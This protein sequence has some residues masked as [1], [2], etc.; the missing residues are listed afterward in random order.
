[1]VVVTGRMNGKGREIAMWKRLSVERNDSLWLLGKMIQ[2][3]VAALLLNAA[4][5][6]QVRLFFSV[7]GVSLLLA[8]A[9]ITFGGLV[10]FIF[11]IPRSGN[12]DAGTGKSGKEREGGGYRPNTN[13]EQ[14]SDWLTKILVGA[15]LTQLTVFPEKLQTLFEYAA[16]QM[17]GCGG[18]SSSVFSGSLI[19]FF[20]V[21]GFM[22]AFLWTRL[23]LARE[24]KRADDDLADLLA[25][26]M[27]ALGAMEQKFDEYDRQNFQM[28]QHQ[29][30]KALAFREGETDAK[31]KLE[32]LSRE[33][34][35][36]RTFSSSG[37]DRT[38]KMGAIISQMRS[39]Y[40]NLNYKPEN[41]IKL[42]KTGSEGNR[43]A[44]L[45]LAKVKA[46]AS[47]F[48]MLIE[49]VRSSKSAFEQYQSLSAIEQVFP[50]LSEDQKAVLKTAITEQMGEEPGKY[51]S[52]G[53]DREAISERLL[54]KIS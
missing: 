41:I 17:R 18:C 24:M 50:Q 31:K 14:I 47:Y 28:L 2:A 20:F 44:A 9:A 49:A 6:G 13:L 36:I 1:M 45:A 12:T 33:Y 48:D 38:V 7:S 40:Y 52:P 15:G 21:S 19:I 22:Y 53:T 54:K 46:D 25:K 29:T 30:E 8:G 42:F 43:I 10:G 27:G 32:A 11:G 3:G 39:L 26:S 4:S 5:S 16:E 51:I 23:N 34:E 35:R 37:K